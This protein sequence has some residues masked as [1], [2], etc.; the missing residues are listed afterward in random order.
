MWRD[1]VSVRRDTPVATD[2]PMVRVRH[3][4]PRIA[5][6]LLGQPR[7]LLSDRQ[8]A[9]VDVLKQQCPGFTRMRRLVLSF[10]AILRHG[11][12]ATLRRWMRRALAS[13]I[14]ALQRFVRT[15]RQDLGAVEGAVREP[16]SNGPVE[17]HINRLKTLRRQMYG[18]AGVELLRARVLPFAGAH[19][20]PTT[21]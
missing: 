18:R 14:H 7:P 17:G 9:A 15:L 20:V 6:A 2:T 21:R 1:P 16:W 10:R 5:A 13:N 4:S 19:H 8:A 11:K 3:L 12:V